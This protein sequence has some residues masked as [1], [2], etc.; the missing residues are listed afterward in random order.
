MMLCRL[1]SLIIRDIL[2]L[3]FNFQPCL[4]Q[5]SGHRQELLRGPFLY[6]AIISAITALYWRDSPVGATAIA[7]LCAGDGFADIV[8]RRYGSGNRLP[9]SLNKVRILP[10]LNGGNIHKE[11]L[12]T[13]LGSQ[14]SQHCT[15]MTCPWG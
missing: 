1:S 7:V 9:H 12:L 4:L 15:G 3:L 10:A 14:L 8:G 11:E 6:G 13:R 5:R 2:L